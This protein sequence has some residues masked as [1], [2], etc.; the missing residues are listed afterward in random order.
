VFNSAG[1][2]NNRIMMEGFCTMFSEEVLLDQIPKAPKDAA[3]RGLVEGGSFPEPP[4]GTV[5]SFEAGIYAEYL[6][7]AKAIRARVGANAVKAAFFQGHVE[8]IGLDPAGGTS[9]PVAAVDRDIVSVPAGITT[10]AVL[11]AAARVPAAEIVAHN[12]GL[13]PTSAVAGRVH[14]PG[15]REHIVVVAG[16]HGAETKAQIAQQNGVT[17]ESLAA[18]NPAASWGSLAAGERILIPRR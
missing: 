17:Q 2:A 16:A 15:A 14:V 10:V 1:G 5:P 3:I 18:A 12:A 11:A 4:A 6:L 7:H 8:F 9:A 13:T